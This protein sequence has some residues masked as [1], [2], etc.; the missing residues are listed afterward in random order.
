[1]FCQKCGNPLQPGERFCTKCGAPV[2]QPA[3]PQQ[4]PQQ[5]PYQQP[6]QAPYQQPYQQPY[7]APR[8]PMAKNKLFGLLTT[9]LFGT[10]ALFELI[11]FIGL[12]TKGGAS[13]YGAGF[14]ISNIIMILGC[15]GIAIAPFVMNYS[16][17][18]I[19][20]SAA[21]LFLGVYGVSTILIMTSVGYLF[22]TLGFACFGI[23]AW[24]YYSG[25]KF[26]KCRWIGFVP[27]GLTFLGCLLN[28]I[29]VKY[30]SGMKFA[31]VF[32]L[33]DFLFGLVIIGAMVIAGF[34]FY[35]T[36]E[37]KSAKINIPNGPRQ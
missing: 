20:A 27:A 11:A 22:Y 2:E 5:A 14:V 21:A 1:M 35:E 3:A 10:A 36:F 17:F 7:Q 31:L 24:L 9:I 29:I 23:L 26:A 34:Y 28:W 8:A 25:N 4:A 33:F 32:Y 16:K 13:I 12:C 6:Q 30:F 15:T 37:E 18:I 19:A